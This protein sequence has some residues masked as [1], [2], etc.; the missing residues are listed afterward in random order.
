MTICPAHGSTVRPAQTGE[1]L[2]SVRVQ[3]RRCR[4]ADMMDRIGGSDALSHPGSRVDRG[5]LRLCSPV[6][7]KLEFEVASIKLSPPP[8]CR[9]WLYC[10]NDR[11]ARNG[12]PWIVPM[13]EPE[14]EGP[15][16]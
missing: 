2:L 8:G 1:G 16:Y 5:A 10:L 4:G 7:V 13:H 15:G 11:R 6:A 3:W 14:V 9:Q 12:E